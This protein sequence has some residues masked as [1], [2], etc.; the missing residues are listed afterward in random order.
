MFELLFVREIPP[1]E[2]LRTSSGGDDEGSVAI[3][4]GSAPGTFHGVFPEGVLWIAAAGA[5]RCMAALVRAGSGDARDTLR[6]SRWGVFGI[7][8]EGTDGRNWAA[9]ELSASAM[10][11]FM[12][13]LEVKSA[14]LRG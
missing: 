6:H 4:T 11:D 8:G 9:L 5:V 2:L 1:R 14:F 7:D 13:D 12:S 3:I 10:I